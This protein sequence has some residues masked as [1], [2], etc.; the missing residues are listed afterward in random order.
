M[1]N[2][3]SIMSNYRRLRN[4]KDAVLPCNCVIWKNEMLFKP[5]RLSM[6]PYQIVY[7]IYRNHLRTRFTPVTARVHV[8]YLPRAMTRLPVQVTERAPWP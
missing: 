4:E 5:A 6:L 8:Y 7:D 2:L 3:V 1:L